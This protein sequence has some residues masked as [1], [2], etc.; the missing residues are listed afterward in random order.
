MPAEQRGSVRRLPSNRWQLRFYDAQGVRHSGGVFATKTEAWSH[1]RNVVEPELRGRPVARRDLTL[2]DLAEVFL[3]RHGKI[4]SPRTIRT[5]RERL[6]RPLRSFKEVPLSE[7]E[8]MADELAG[9]AAG[10]PDRYRHAV[11]LALRQTL[12][13]GVRYGYL[14]KNPAKLMGPN[15]APAP[16]PVRPFSSD[17]LGRITGEL[18]GR[19]AAAIRFAAATGLR[20]SEWANLERRD[21]D[22]GR[23]ILTVR[24]TKTRGSR[25][26]VPLTTAA[27]VALDQ[28]PPRLDSPYM[29]AG[30]KGG[31][32]DVENFRKRDWRTAIDTAGIAR[33]ARLYDLRSTFASHALAAGITVYELARLLGS[34][35]RM[36]EAHYGALLDTAH[37]A[38]LERLEGITG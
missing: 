15:P 5:L 27:L 24:G 35:V 33:P 6:Q 22:R 28:L 31:P 21:V 1:F 34:S 10:L 2:G 16:R 25:R 26:E 32:F 29:F 36:I 19:G 18:D 14:T 12:E 9:F 37:D 7:V 8:G 23:R 13:A 30:P 4:A 11:V 17:E 3:D 20:P 38:I